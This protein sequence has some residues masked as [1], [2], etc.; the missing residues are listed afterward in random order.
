[1][2]SLSSSFVISSELSNIKSLFNWLESGLFKL[3]DN[4]E[5]VN[6]LSLM[7]Q[8]AL[9]NAI[10]H[11]NKNIKTKNVTLSYLLNDREVRIVIE[12]EGDGVDLCSQ[13]KKHTNIREEDLLQ[14]S[15]RGIILMKYFCKDVIF[16][17]NSIEMYLSNIL[18]QS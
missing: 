5:K 16:K 11:G 12:D 14:D 4:K 3:I 17:K 18:I 2:N 10:V 7:I 15:G 1:M 9:V 6:A 13:Q 8:E